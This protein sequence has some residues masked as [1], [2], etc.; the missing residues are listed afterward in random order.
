MNA[1]ITLS[2][3]AFV[4][5]SVA[6]FADAPSTSV[7]P[8]S[9]STVYNVFYKSTETGKVKVSIF[10]SSNDMVFTET[11]SNVSSFKR[12]Y[13]FSELA[14]GQYTIVIEDKNGKSVE[15]VNY[16]MN[17]VQSF[18]AVSQVAKAENK[19]ALN[20]T[21]NG[22]ESAN[23]K[24]YSDNVLVHEQDVVVTKSFGTIYNLNKIKSTEGIRFE[25]TTSNGKTQV[26]TF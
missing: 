24:I 15:N 12:P 18:V 17:K 1:R 23:I 10:N 2:I 3:F 4:M 8:V 7:V 22:S 5:M 14:E 21:N 9:N 20:I 19:Y 13:N 11:L 16:V 26:A 25:V 6:A